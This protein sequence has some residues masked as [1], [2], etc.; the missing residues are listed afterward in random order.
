YPVAFLVTD[1]CNRAL[2][3]GQARRVVYAGFALA[4]VLSIAFAGWR[5][6][7]ASGTAFLSA[8][9]LDV[10]VFDRLR[11]LR[12]WQA[13][14]ISS[15]LASTLDTLL[16]FA[17]AFAGTA[18]PWV[19][20]ALGDYAV[21]LLVALVLLIPFRALIAVLPHAG[22]PTRRPANQPAGGP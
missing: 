4:V 9:L 22:A 18:V 14:L 6:A 7:L 16:F 11:R 15:T 10:T 3:P 12:W 19:T 20:L 13:P 1:L 17:L 8:Q 2:G 5:I 21:K